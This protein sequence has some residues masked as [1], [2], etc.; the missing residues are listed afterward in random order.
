MDPELGT[1]EKEMA[2]REESIR[3]FLDEAGIKGQ[4]IET[5]GLPNFDDQ[6]RSHTKF[7][8]IKAK[9]GRAATSFF[10]AL[11]ESSSSNQHGPYF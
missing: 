8:V 2:R 3:V 9:L 6:I 11:G 10:V 1:G 5:E 4:R 7:Q